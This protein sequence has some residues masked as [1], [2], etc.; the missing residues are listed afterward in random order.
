[1][2]ADLRSVD[3]GSLPSWPRQCQHPARLPGR[4]GLLTLA[5]LL[6]PGNRGHQGQGSQALACTCSGLKLEQETLMFF[7]ASGMFSLWPRPR[8]ALSVSPAG[9]AGREKPPQGWVCQHSAFQEP[10]AYTTGSAGAPEP[11][12]SD[13]VLDLRL[14]CSCLSVH[15][16]SFPPGPL[17]VSGFEDSGRWAGCCR[18]QTQAQSQ[19]Q[20]GRRRLPCAGS[21]C[22]RC[23]GGQAGIAC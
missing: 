8:P 21:S 15:A 17:S 5:L 12:K 22:L 4:L 7:A 14:S 19:R 20:T 23:W 18:P 9:L 10:G 11:G 6:R 1:M 2:G 13:H 16:P 3:A